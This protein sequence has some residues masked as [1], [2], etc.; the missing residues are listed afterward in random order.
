MW[1]AVPKDI[2]A[3]HRP[4]IAF[5]DDKFDVSGL[6]IPKGMASIVDNS[7]GELAGKKLVSG[8]SVTIPIRNF[9]EEGEA[10]LTVTS[11]NY[12]PYIATIR[13]Q[14]ISG[15]HDP[16]M[17]NKKSIS[18]RIGKQ[19]VA[20]VK[21]AANTGINIFLYNLKGQVLFHHRVKT[22]VEGYIDLPASIVGDGIYLL[23]VETNEQKLTGDVI[24]FNQ[25]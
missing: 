9:T 8:S 15:I 13:V 18:I 5:S 6:N 4:D 17:V 25:R 12:I 2:T 14:A 21:C 11:H 3:N 19:V 16:G 10:T 7:T 23:N 24:F 1:T 20:S 22:P